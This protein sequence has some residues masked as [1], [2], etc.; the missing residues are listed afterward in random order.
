MKAIVTHN[1]IVFTKLDIFSSSFPRVCSKYLSKNPPSIYNRVL[2]LVGGSAYK[3]SSTIVDWNLKRKIE[4]ETE[5]ER[6]LRIKLYKINLQRLPCPQ[7]LNNDK[8]GKLY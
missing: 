4:R 8:A 3:L 6:P 7:I 5:T 2:I 1:P